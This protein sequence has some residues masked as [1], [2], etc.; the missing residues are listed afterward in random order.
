[1]PLRYLFG[2][3][4]PSFA[5]E[6]LPGACARGECRPFSL[7]DLRRPSW[8]AFAATFPDGF[9]PDF[10][11]VDLPY[12]AFPDWLREAPVPLVG[13]AGDAPLLWH[14]YRR[15]D[16][17]DLLLADA[18]AADQLRRQGLTNVRA[19][20][21]YG[22]ERPFLAEPPGDEGRDI[23]ALFVGN[24]HPAV[25][26]ARLPW[27]ARLARLSRRWN[28]LVAANIWGDDYRA[29]LRR[30]RI[31]FNRSARSE[32]NRRVGECFGAGALLFSERGN[33][34]ASTLLRDRVDSVLY[35]DTD[36]EDLLEHFLTHEDERRS[37]ARAGRARAAEFAFESIW[38][39]LL[40]VI[41]GELPA[42]RERAIRRPASDPA[43]GLLARTWRW[44]AVGFAADL[45]LL[46][47]LQRA[48]A[49]NPHDAELHNACAVALTLAAR[50]TNQGA[51]LHPRVVELLRRALTLDPGHTVVAL[52][53]VEVLLGVNDRAAA[54][55]LARDTLLRLEQSSAA[56]PSWLDAPCLPP[57]FEL[58]RVEWERAG[59]D[60]PGDPAGEGHAKRAL[61]RWRLHLVL[62]LLSGEVIHYHEA[63][64]ARP[65]LP[66]SQAA[67]GCALGQL[68]RPTV[69]LSHLRAA[70]DA[71]P[72]DEDAARALHQACRDLGDVEAAHRVAQDHRLL[73]RAA[74][75]LVPDRG[76]DAEAAP[77]ATGG[78][79]P[80]F[81][82][83]PLADFEHRY[84]P[85]DTARALCGF[86]PPADTRTVLTLLAALRPKRVLE[87]GTALGHMTANLTEWSP[88]DAVV[89]T[90]GTT[91]DM[92]PA[93]GPAQQ[94]EAPPREALGR[95]AGHFGKRHKVRQI[96]ADSLDHDFQTLAPIDFAFIDGAHDLAHVLSDTRK[97]Y[98]ALAPGGCI[99]WHDFGSA[100][101]WVE[102][103]Q[104]LERAGLPEPI[105]HVAGTQVAFLIKSGGRQEAGVRDQASGTRVGGAPV[106]GERQPSSQT[107]GAR[108]ARGGEPPFII[109]WEGGFAAV[110]SLALVNREISLRLAARGH[111][112]RLLPSESD[113]APGVPRLPLPPELAARLGGPLS[114]PPEFTIRHRWPPDLR[115]ASDGR[116][117]V[118]QPWE[119][120]STPRDWLRPFTEDVDEVWVPSRF[121]R[122]C[123]IADGVPAERVHVIPL[124][125]DVARFRPDAPPL[126]LRT[127]KRFRFLFV[128]GTIGRKGA[129]ILLD[130]F[131]RAFTSDDDVCLVI[132]EM[133]K[134]SFYA[135]QT[136]EALIARLCSTPR[137]PEIEYI[138]ESLS[139]DQLAGLY[140]ACD[141]LVHPYRGEGFGLPIVEAMACALPVIVTGSGAAL[142]FCDEQNAH[143]IPAR[144][145]EFR[146]QR[147][148]DL[149]TV[150]RPWLAEPDLDALV[151]LLR[152]AVARPEEGRIKGLA[153]CDRVRRRL[154]WDHTAAAVEA[155]LFH[156]RSR[157][158]RRR[159]IVPATPALPPPPPP[160]KPPPPESSRS[161]DP[162]ARGREIERDL[163]A[164][165]AEAQRRPSDH[166]VHFKLG[167]F[168][169]QTGGHEKAV[170][171]L[172][173]CLDLSPPGASPDGAH[174]MLVDSLH[175]LRRPAE[176]LAACRRGRAAAPHDPGLLFREGVLLRELKNYTA[177]EAC[178]LELLSSGSHVAAD[179]SLDW[180]G[181][182][183]L[184]EVLFGQ[185][186]FAEARSQWRAALEWRPGLTAAWARL[187]EAAL[188]LGDREGLDE[189]LRQLDAV[190]DGQTT[191]GVLRGRALL[192]AGDF[193]AARAAAEALIAANPRE[194]NPRLLLSEALLREGRDFA[195]AERALR[196]VLLLAPAHA[197]AQSGL[198]SVLR[199]RLRTE[200]AVFEALGDLT[201]WQLG[202]RYEQACLA[203]S[204]IR[205]ALPQLYELARGCEHI[206]DLGTGEGLATTAFLWAQPK[207]L[208]CCD[209]VRSAGFDELLALAGETRLVFVQEDS[210][211]ADLPETDLLFVDTRHDADLLREE[212]ARHAGRARKYVVLHGST[213]FA[214]QGETP[215]AAGLAAVIHE[216][217]ARGEFRV[218]K[219]DDAGHG[220]TVLE[221]IA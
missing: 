125:V 151:A 134:G 39:R 69:A 197:Q 52:N 53:L 90:V 199:R 14:G 88:D 8:E 147:V 220:L 102:V 202:T 156:L 122:D 213:A 99:A 51:E 87:I 189:A 201:G 155:R 180:R 37:I 63:V 26:R 42:L 113:S 50:A 204:D 170:F 76:W 19:G 54:T 211:R 18:P 1:M 161:E 67:L 121:V 82:T 126:P 101:P 73:R 78:S 95:F 216:F 105:V 168:F 49:A 10:V 205:D 60:H 123:F 145:V 215:G 3:V 157:P 175:A 118:M 135:G 98:Q 70:V 128:G 20:V 176:A 150:S 141:C 111:E 171:H 154:T 84:G 25:Q 100:T 108:P 104:A 107:S 214:A 16:A 169:R 163:E 77:A 221:R 47:D 21:I 97:V 190:P 44:L 66:V 144:K 29:L 58:L 71:N 75:G 172:Q 92:P 146:E 162:A 28:V 7:D 143:L 103:R 109:M 68:G 159:T 196:E 186:R 81:V 9:R 139:F 6:T 195:A 194:L 174:A 74:P 13:L 43:A 65:D 209:L 160:P 152:R 4:R 124:G 218:L 27:I 136:A 219:R 206:T 217:L 208:V 132:K 198:A 165:W 191:A 158:V 2:P 40:E 153:G 93:C 137:A 61:A 110:H 45:G 117:V 185:G 41:A 192:E 48:V 30:A 96:V 187:G 55:E 72:F 203:T 179:P 129:D 140:T 138:E 23:H 35:D 210:R 62:G 130:A 200:N 164:L 114:R 31:V 127:R 178:F 120:G 166:D 15:L 11:A 167:M 193:A 119:F 207:T 64:L 56:Q 115:P 89:F 24:I 36:L 94:Y 133:G 32:L 59:W 106:Q 173:Q 112:L 12:L 183:E 80:T 5:S 148:G 116:L 149:E 34:E 33:L 85:A 142:D 184:A 83:L 177:A 131:A 181:R 86:T 91:A 38:G 79:R 188:A 17:F 46:P 57:G 212:L 22:V 182:Y